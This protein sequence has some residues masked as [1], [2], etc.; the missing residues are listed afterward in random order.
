MAGAVAGVGAV[1]AGIGTLFAAGEARTRRNQMKDL[2]NTPGLD[3]DSE[4]ASAYGSYEKNLPTAS[5]IAG[6]VN[7]ANAENMRKLLEAGI[8]GY[9]GLQGQAIGNIGSE[10][11][12]E[13]PPD[14]QAAIDRATA[15]RAVAGG[16]GGSGMH[17]NLTAR[18]LGLT[19]LNLSQRGQQDLNALVSGTPLPG[20][21]SAGSLLGPSISDRIGIRG[22]ERTQKLMLMAQALGLP[23]NT[24]VVAQHLQQE[25]GMLEGAGL[26]G[27]GFGGK[28][29]GGGSGLNVQPGGGY[30]SSMM[31]GG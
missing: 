26:G 23:T 31:G 14:V 11:R 20:L 13:L 12:G 7:T 6:G 5:R 15:A 19:S 24:E 8:P 4:I 9:E 29:S 3:I 21:V 25:G 17:R 28:P 16:Y 2:A 18:D 30:Y 1:E 10:L 27:M 22:N